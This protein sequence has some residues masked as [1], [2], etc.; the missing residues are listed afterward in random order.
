LQELVQGK[1]VQQR[2]NDEPATELLRKINAEKEKLIA[3]GKLKKDKPLPPITD[4]E[5]P[6][7]LPKGWVWCRLGEIVNLNSGVTLGKAYSGSLTTVPYLR[8]ANV[9][10]GYL[11]L[12]KVKDISVPSSEVEK[13]KLKHGDLLMVEGGDWDKVGRCAIWR[14]EI[15]ICIHQNHIFR[16]RF[17]GGISNEW[18]ELYLNSPIAR[19]YFESC[20]KQTTNLASINQTQLRNLLFPI[21]PIPTQIKC[22]EKVRS[23]E[24]LCRALK[25]SIDE[26]SREAEQLL[27]NILRTAF[28]EPEQMESKISIAE[29]S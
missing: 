26:C 23:V 13:Y 22:T 8:V 4:E 14:N 7:E 19:R 6:F 10:R 3:E 2:P 9:Q 25:A 12:E 29:L 28:N 16:L 5:I 15:N 1:L 17:Y 18:A 24:N 21:P 27:E 20:S 11:D